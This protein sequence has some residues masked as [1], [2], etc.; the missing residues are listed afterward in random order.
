MLIYESDDC[1]FIDAF[2]SR[3]RAI[4]KGYFRETVPNA[5][6][7]VPRLSATKSL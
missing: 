1:A 2:M 4:L 6:L 3:S 5:F 7:T